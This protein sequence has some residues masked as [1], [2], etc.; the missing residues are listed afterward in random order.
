MNNRE[1]Y[2]KHQT[3]RAPWTADVTL[4]NHLDLLDIPSGPDEC[5]AA[6]IDVP[7]NLRRRKAGCV[8]TRDTLATREDGTLGIDVYC[9]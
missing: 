6:R 2:R 7:N 4:V 5:T 9:G 8:F 1:S 3:R